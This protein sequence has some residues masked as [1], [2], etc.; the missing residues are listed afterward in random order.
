MCK[1][2][3][4]MVCQQ[5]AFIPTLRLLKRLQWAKKCEHRPGAVIGNSRCGEIGKLTQLTVKALHGPDML[6]IMDYGPVVQPY[7]SLRIFAIL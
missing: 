1:C 4:C 2:V 3:C 6:Q 7:L 5:C